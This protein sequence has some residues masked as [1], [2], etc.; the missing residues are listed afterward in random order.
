MQVQKHD[1]ND[2]DNDE[3]NDEVIDDEVGDE[4]KLVM[5]KWMS[6]KLMLKKIM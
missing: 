2:D 5:M 3:V 4:M 6:M 1:T